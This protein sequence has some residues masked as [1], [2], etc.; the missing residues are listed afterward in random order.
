MLVCVCACCCLR[1]LRLVCL[2]VYW[3]PYGVLFDCYCFYFIYF[4][5]FLLSVLS[6]MILFIPL[7]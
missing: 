6:C 2:V 1:G 5:V 7:P 4:Y 3:G